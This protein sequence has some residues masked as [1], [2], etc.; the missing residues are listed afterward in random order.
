MVD[1]LS[2][3]QDG[4]QGRRGGRESPGRGLP[5]WEEVVAGDC[6]LLAWGGDTITETKNKKQTYIVNKQEER[7]YNYLFLKGTGNKYISN[8]EKLEV[9]GGEKGGSII[10][11]KLPPN[12]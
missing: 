8:N 7:K 10:F 2:K 12:A 4:E 9:A 11:E 5:P 1:L 6:K 3:G